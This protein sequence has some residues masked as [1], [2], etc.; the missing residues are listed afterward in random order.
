ML[1]SAILWRLFLVYADVPHHRQPWLTTLPSRLN[2][3]PTPRSFG[4]N[5]ATFIPLSRC[6][7]AAVQISLVRS[8]PWR[9]WLMF[10]IH[11]KVRTIH[12][13]VPEVPDSVLPSS[14]PGWNAHKRGSIDASKTINIMFKMYSDCLVI[15]TCDTI[16][17]YFV[18]CL[19][20]LHIYF[21]LPQFVCELFVYLYL[22]MLI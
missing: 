8:T 22:C 5:V 4:G 1:L 16:V 17:H 7:Y 21:C 18:N 3:P 2:S 19:I 20:S 10:L 13:L 9:P 6:F 15:I 14:S 11:S 12:C